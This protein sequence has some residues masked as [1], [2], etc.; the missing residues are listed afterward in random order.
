MLSRFGHPANRP[1]RKGFAVIAAGSVLLT[2]ALCWTL[3]GASQGDNSQYLSPGEIAIS[4]DGSRL[5]VT[6]EASNELRIVDT[7]TGAIL[8][9]VSVGRVLRGLA[10]SP[11]GSRVYVAN[12]W[13]DNITVVDA[14]GFAVL[15]TLPA[16]WEPTS[17]VT[18][19]AGKN[20]Y[21]ADRLS[22]DIAVI[23]VTANESK[24]IP[25]G[26]GASY[27]ARAGNTPFIH[28]SHVTPASR[29]CGALRNLK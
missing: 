5:Y 29:V 7:R 18:D 28:C 16:G 3:Q 22:D 8:K 15:R 25:A 12:S 4:P 20:L 27:L 9:T 23:D 24:R 11:D 17:V 13:D 26:R 6:C 1:E 19:L 10:L 14:A 2:L 21:V